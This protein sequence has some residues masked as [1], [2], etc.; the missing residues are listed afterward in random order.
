MERFLYR[1]RSPYA[2]RFVLKGAMLFSAWD[3]V[4]RQPTRD[5]DLLGFGDDAVAS[6]EKV[7]A[8]IVQ[9]DA[10]QAASSSTKA[11]SEETRSERT[12]S[13]EGCGFGSAPLWPVPASLCRSTS[14]SETS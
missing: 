13:M 3:E 2:E 7:V 6:V 4:P 9:V 8:E 5:L 12:K 1:L 11:P 14:H 10:E